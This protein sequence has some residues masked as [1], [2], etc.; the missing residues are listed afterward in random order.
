MG[1][2]NASTLEQLQKDWP[3]D[4]DQWSQGDD[5]LR[6][7]KSCLKRQFPGKNGTGYNK[8]ITASED[9]LNF[10][11]GVTSPIQEQF[12]ELSNEFVLKAGDTMTG[13]L[14]IEHEC[15][16][17]RDTSPESDPIS[18][19]AIYGSNGFLRGA[20]AEDDDH[21]HKAVYIL[22]EGT[23]EA[24]SYDTIAM[25]FKGNINMS[26]PGGYSIH[27][28]APGDLTVK[29]YVDSQNFAVQQQVTAANVEVSSLVSRLA[30]AEALLISVQNALQIAQAKLDTL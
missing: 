27:P 16:V 15:R 4:S 13:S 17:L 24:T 6:N 7:L 3:Y 19:F 1:I 5:H 12:A 21:A 20:F 22:Q 23:D 18:G 9:E 2:E 25:F 10:V 30:T 26:S 14:N 28:S 29:S 8:T 11:D